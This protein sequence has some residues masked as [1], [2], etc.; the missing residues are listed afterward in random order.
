MAKAIMICGKLCSGKS[1]YAQVLREQ[2]HAVVLS[3]D[4]M[5]LTL[6]PEGAGKQ[7]DT[8]TKRTT[9]YLLQKSL[10]ILRCH[11]SVILDWGFWTKESRDMVKQ[12]FLSNGVGYEFHYLHVGDSVWQQRIEQRNAEVA[13]GESLNYKVDQGLLDK[14]EAMFEEPQ[15][16][17]MD[18]W[19]EIG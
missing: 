1:T 10:E 11:V 16:A 17:E 12:F 15:R 19:I 4:E 7:H 8:Y 18:G 9:D 13:R 14:F 5:M 2:R 3:I 6:F